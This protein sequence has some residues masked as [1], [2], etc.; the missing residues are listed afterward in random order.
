M[1]VFGSGWVV[2]S[3]TSSSSEQFLWREMA[4]IIITKGYFP[5][6][7]NGWS[8]IHAD[9]VITPFSFS[10]IIVFS[11]A[12]IYRIRSGSVG[13]NLTCANRVHAR[14]SLERKRY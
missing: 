1:T 3:V 13:L 11:S 9:L 14:S 5:F 8:Q 2:K 7:E 10:F 12:F 4:Y 6:Q